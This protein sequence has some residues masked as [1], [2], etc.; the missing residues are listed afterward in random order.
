M[1]I[2]NTTQVKDELPTVKVLIGRK[3]FKGFLSGRKNPFAT[4]TVYEWNGDF[5]DWQFSWET[6]TNAINTNQS[7]RV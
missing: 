7:L 5:L 4:V 3:I 6:V 2:M 1:A